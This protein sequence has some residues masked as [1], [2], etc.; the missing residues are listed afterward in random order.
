MKQT[1]NKL[2]RLY[3]RPVMTCI[4]MKQRASLLDASGPFRVY[5]EEE[6]SVNPEDTW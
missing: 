6:E 1:T 4:V 3:T 5:N 2:R